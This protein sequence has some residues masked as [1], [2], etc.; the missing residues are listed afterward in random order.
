MFL[1]SKFALILLAGA[2][3]A[4]VANPARVNAQPLTVTSGV[5][6][7]FD[8]ADSSTIFDSAGVNPG[9]AGFNAETVSE[10]KDKSSNANHMNSDGS[11]PSYV[12]GGMPAVRFVD[13]NTLRSG[14]TGLPTTEARTFFFVGTQTDNTGGSNTEEWYFSYGD[15]GPL[16]WMAFRTDDES[17]GFQ[18]PTPTPVGGDN[19]YRNLVTTGGNESLKGGDVYD[20]TS[21]PGAKIIIEYSFDGE[22]T[23]GAFR[24]YINGVLDHEIFQ[25]GGLNTNL[26]GGPAALGIGKQAAGSEANWD[27]NEL[28]LYN[29]VLTA[30]ERSQVYGYLTAKWI[31]EPSSMMLLLAGMSLCFFRRRRATV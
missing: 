26:S 13:R 31:P 2:P 6:M 18:D 9:G 1:R 11:D 27:M 23:G 14:T 24:Q 29:K 19:I 3:I 7:H 8:A 15:A 12:R 20:V 4:L 17:G 10:W 28:I 21:P 30:G 5:A 22:S 16:T 25:D